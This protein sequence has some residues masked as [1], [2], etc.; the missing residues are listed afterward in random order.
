M[1]AFYVVGILVNSQQF[2]HDLFY[3][4]KAIFTGCFAI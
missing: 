2:V 1:P 4:T 3:K